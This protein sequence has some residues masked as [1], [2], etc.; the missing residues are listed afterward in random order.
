[1]RG[2]IGQGLAL[3]RGR[4]LSCDLSRPEQAPVKHQRPLYK[5]VVSETVS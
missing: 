4:V 5:Y 2:G 1:M 3:C